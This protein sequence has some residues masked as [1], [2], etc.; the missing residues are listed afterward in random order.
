[1]LCPSGEGE[2]EGDDAPDTP[3]GF[4]VGAIDLVYRES[5]SDALVVADFK[6][7]AV[8]EGD[9][10]ALDAVAKRYAA[11]GSVYTRAVQEAL[12]TAEL[13]RFELWLLDPGI[14]LPG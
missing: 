5:G 14:V 6:T 4:L 11:Q 13:P 1:M 8:P 3:V 10:A 7:E 9:D 12:G 2:G